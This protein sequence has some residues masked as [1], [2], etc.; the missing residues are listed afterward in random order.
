MKDLS[1][2]SFLGA[3]ATAAGALSVVTASGCGAPAPGPPA[4]AKPVSGSF[5]H[6]LEGISR[7]NIKITDVKTTRISYKPS[8][9]SYI[10][11]CGP[12][13]LTKRD[14]GITRIF[15]DQGIVGIGPG[16]K[17]YL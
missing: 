17:A 9:G 4:S 5:T 14:A 13:V 10:H 2:R 3:S 6:L 12:V 8:D 7:E 11:E 15:T 16:G 1:R